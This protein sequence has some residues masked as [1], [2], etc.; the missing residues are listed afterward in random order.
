MPNGVKCQSAKTEAKTHV[1]MARDPARRRV[2]QK[3]RVW[4]PHW[5]VEVRQRCAETRIIII[6]TS[7]VSNIAATNF[8]I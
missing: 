5:T 1:G 3:T 2:R 4:V 6:I 8:Y 7:H